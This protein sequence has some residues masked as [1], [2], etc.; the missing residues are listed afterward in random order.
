MIEQAPYPW[1]RD[2]WQ[3]WQR[4]LAQT[5]V[6][7]AVL[8]YGRIGCGVNDFAL[9]LCCSLLCEQDDVDKPCLKCN[10]C[11]LFLSGNHPDCLIIEAEQEQIKIEQVRK[12]I[13]FLQLSR[14]YMSHKVVLIK[15]ADNLNY[16]AANSLLKTL[17][18]PPA[19]SVIILTCRQ[20]SILT[21]TIR[22]RCHRIYLKEPAAEAIAWLA[23][24]MSIS[25]EEARQK[26][27]L[28]N[29]TPLS[30][31]NKVSNSDD[32][33]LFYSELKQWLGRQ[34]TTHDFVEHWHDRSSVEI[35]QWLL[36]YLHHNAL[37]RAKEM[38]ADQITTSSS[39]NNLG[40]LLYWL[41]QRQIERCRLAKQNI[42]PRL[43]L[44]GSLMEWRKAY[45][46]N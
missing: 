34:M 24:Q 18:E 43:L 21:P 4:Y 45:H 26:L 3:N 23:E 7:H 9:K 29:N 8:L 30:V 13:E 38:S 33:S 2:A 20:P 39:K 22:S 10:G 14:H 1:Q 36:E 16:A 28:S 5:K 31:L 40:N 15:E 19:E 42:N 11:R 37:E 35:Q 25:L 17:E 6:P 12:A 27:R 46:G 44:E 32:K 41:Y